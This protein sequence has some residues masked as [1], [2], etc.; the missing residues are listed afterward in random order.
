MRQ[1]FAAAAEARLAYFVPSLESAEAWAASLP[2]YRDDLKQL[3]GW[4]WTEVAEPEPPA[5]RREAVGRDE[6][7]TIERVHAEAL[8]GVSM[9][10]LLFLPEHD[11]KPV[12]LRGL[13]IAQHGGLGTPEL[14]ANFFRIAN[15]GDLVNRLRQRGLAVLAPQVT[16]WAPDFHPGP[17]DEITP[18]A[19]PDRGDPAGLNPGQWHGMLTATGGTLLGLESFGILRLLDAALAMPELQDTPVGMFGLSYGGML[20]LLTS[21]LEPR[22]RVAAASA[23]MNDGSPQAVMHDLAWP[24][25][26]RQFAPAEL[27]GLICPRPL[28]LE[29]GRGDDHIIV[30]NAAAAV[31]HVSSWYARLG[32]ADRLLYHEHAGGHEIDRA[33]D[34][35]F[36]FVDRHL[37]AGS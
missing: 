30:A 21:A 32:I 5:L 9:Y 13:V 2:K 18:G 14:V 34:A 31:G 33:D 23:C 6:F 16:R 25:G 19:Q 12:P 10:G 28:A 37:S 1:R 7:G 15:Y 29:I 8:P 17:E 36:D 24:G 35:V 11:D 22:I 3:L 26:L 27:G 4:P 20:T